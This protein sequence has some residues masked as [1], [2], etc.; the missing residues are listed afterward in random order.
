MVIHSNDYYLKKMSS[1]TRKIVLS[2]LNKKPDRTQLNKDVAEYYRLR[3]ITDKKLGNR[4][5]NFEN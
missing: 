5:E 4:N 3:K 2:I 1:D